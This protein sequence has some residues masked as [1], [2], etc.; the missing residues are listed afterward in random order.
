[1][2]FVIFLKNIAQC[3]NGSKSAQTIHF[4]LTLFLQDNTLKKG[5]RG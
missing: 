4:F 3:A 1:V 5:N 2:F